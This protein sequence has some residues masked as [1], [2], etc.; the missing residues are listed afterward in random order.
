MGFR[1]RGSAVLISLA[2]G[3]GVLGGCGSSSSNGTEGSSSSSGGGSA[4]PTAGFSAKAKPASFGE[5][6]SEEARKQASETL[7]R[8]MS[9]R[10]AG[11]YA[12]QCETLSTQIVEQIEK[13]SGGKKSCAEVLETEAK[14]VP[15][16][17]LANTLVE[18]IAAL[19][20]KG[21]AGYAIYHGK[22]N[23]DYAVRMELD[24]GE[25]KVATTIPEVLPKG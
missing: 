13:S 1:P 5:E 25:W 23:Q 22:E 24:N 2:L 20:I 6:S 4:K 14:K 12:I 21:N 17:L 18:P 9:A 19:R 3:V 16:A 8:N 7:E 15:P 11:S 10:G